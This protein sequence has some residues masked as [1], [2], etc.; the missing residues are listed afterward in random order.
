MND[1]GKK[2]EM[3]YRDLFFKKESTI[4]GLTK[5]LHEMQLRVQQMEMMLGMQRDQQ[6]NTANRS[7]QTESEEEIVNRETAWILQRSKR[8]MKEFHEELKINVNHI[9]YIEMYQKIS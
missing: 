2:I 3:K 4:Q 1:Y 9:L 5:Q 7:F 8:K 6:Q